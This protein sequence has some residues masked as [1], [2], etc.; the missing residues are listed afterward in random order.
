MDFI[1]FFN[2][3]P[4]SNLARCIIDNSKNFDDEILPMTSLSNLPAVI[5]CLKKSP[6]RDEPVRSSDIL[7]TYVWPGIDD[8][9]RVS[10]GWNEPFVIDGE[11][12]LLENF[13]RYDNEFAQME[14]GARNVE[15][16]NEE[17]GKYLTMDLDTLDIDQN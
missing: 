10:F 9:R 14:W 8:N 7:V 17:T 1:F 3:K 5:G 11:E 16:I 13:P 4:E 15:I 6:T 2:R 12:I